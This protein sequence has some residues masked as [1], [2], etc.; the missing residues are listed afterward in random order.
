MILGLVGLH[1]NTGYASHHTRLIESACNLV[2]W[3][4]SACNLVLFTS[5]E[6]SGVSIHSIWL[7]YFRGLFCSS[8]LLFPACQN[9][10]SSVYLQLAA[11]RLTFFHYTEWNLLSFETINGH[12]YCLP[13]KYR[14]PSMNFIIIWEIVILLYRWLILFCECIGVRPVLVNPSGNSER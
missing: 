9:G 8:K 4:E 7:S 14:G 11:Q 1:L 6:K 2:L 13:S 5:D 3:I 10:I 12:V